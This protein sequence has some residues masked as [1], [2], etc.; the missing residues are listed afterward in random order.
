M[1]CGVVRGPGEW[2]GLRCRVIHL[3]SGVAAAKMERDTRC[4]GVESSATWMERL[5]RREGSAGVVFFSSCSCWLVSVADE[6]AN[7]F[8]TGLTG[9]G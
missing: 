3:S 6:R 9:G 7:G 1:I 8:V 4:L 2:S 5:L